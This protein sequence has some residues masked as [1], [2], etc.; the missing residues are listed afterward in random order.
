MIFRTRPTYPTDPIRDKVVKRV[1]GI[2]EPEL[3]DWADVTGSGIARS[4]REYQKSGEL[5]LL[6]EAR[7]GVSALQAVIDSLVER[8]SRK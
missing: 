4:L 8:S 6:Q 1:A 3:L 2:S 5:L 7:D